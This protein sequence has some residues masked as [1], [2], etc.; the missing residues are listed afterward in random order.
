M[1]NLLDLPGPVDED[2]LRSMLRDTEHHHDLMFGARPAIEV[3]YELAGQAI[4]ELLHDEK[5]EALS[6]REILNADDFFLKT[7]DIL[8][9]FYVPKDKRVRANVRVNTKSGYDFV[10]RQHL[11]F[12]V[13]SCVIG[14]KKEMTPDDIDLLKVVLKVTPKHG[15]DTI[16]EYYI[17]CK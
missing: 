6:A 3:L 2:L 9:L 14:V 10:G 15:F 13:D 5:Q 8:D 12:N 4:S 1:I 17:A 16:W 7:L 11:I